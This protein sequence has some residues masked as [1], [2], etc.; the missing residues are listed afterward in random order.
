MDGDDG[1]KS[2]A[3]ESLFPDFPPGGALGARGESAAAAYLRSQKGY[4][5][6]ALNWRNPDD[7]REEIDLVAWDG[8]ALVFVEVK[9]RADGARVPGYYAVDASKR[10]VLRRSARS[11]LRGLRAAR[12][13]RPRTFR[14][15]VIEIEH[16]TGEPAARLRHFRNIPLFLRYERA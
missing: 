1:L 6:A 2:G 16:R 4:R 10:A 11:Y 5:I 13:E 12:G 8:P 9:T 14:F 3:E 15:D 7:M